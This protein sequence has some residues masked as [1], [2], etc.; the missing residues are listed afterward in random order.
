MTE[1]GLF[2]ATINLATGDKFELES[3]AT[4]YTLQP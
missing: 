4:A 1:L 2:K 3:G